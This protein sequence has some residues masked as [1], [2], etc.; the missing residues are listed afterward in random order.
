MPG[1]DALPGLSLAGG[2]GPVLEGCPNQHF[3]EHTFFARKRQMVPAWPEEHPFR[4]G[5]RSGVP[6]VFPELPGLR[7]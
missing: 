1:I 6:R 7:N 4:E 2:K 3:D 5:V